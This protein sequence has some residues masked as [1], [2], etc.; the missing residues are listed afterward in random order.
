M[1]ADPVRSSPLGGH[2]SR[3]E[4]IDLER[5]EVKIEHGRVTLDGKRTATDDPKSKASRR[6][7]EVDRIHTGTVALLRSLRARQKADRLAA[8]LRTKRADWCL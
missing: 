3:W 7:V 5:G 8:G 6:T 4:C 1:T 2:G